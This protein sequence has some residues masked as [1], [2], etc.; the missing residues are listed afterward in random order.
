MAVYEVIH[1]GGDAGVVEVDDTG[2]T[3]VLPNQELRNPAGNRTRR[4]AIIVADPANTLPVFLR[5]H[6]TELAEAGKGIP[7]FPGFFYEITMDNLYMGAIRA[8]VAAGT[9]T[10]FIHDGH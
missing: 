9:E 5:L 7:L 1:G 6:Q 8:V 2:E 4:Y 3:I 10:L